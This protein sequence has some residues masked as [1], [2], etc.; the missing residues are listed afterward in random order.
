MLFEESSCVCMPS[1]RPVALSLFWAKVPFL[2]WFEYRK[3]CN[4]MD[5]FETTWVGVVLDFHSFDTP[6]DSVASKIKEYIENMHAH[7]LRAIYK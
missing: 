4:H 6:L 1:F 3:R 7:R 2:A 5:I